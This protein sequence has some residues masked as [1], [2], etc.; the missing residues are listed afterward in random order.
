MSTLSQLIR[1]KASQAELRRALDQLSAWERVRDH[2]LFK[3][4]MADLAKT[5]R[6]TA[7]QWKRLLAG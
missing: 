1:Q 6:A 5:H 4:I 2:E 7:R 3:K